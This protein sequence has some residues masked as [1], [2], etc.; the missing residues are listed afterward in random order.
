VKHDRLYLSQAE[1]ELRRKTTERLM[2]HLPEMRQMAQEHES[3]MAYPTRVP[4][5][6]GRSAME[7]GETGLPWHTPPPA[8]QKE[9]LSERFVS[10]VGETSVGFMQGGEPTLWHRTPVDTSQRLLQTYLYSNEPAFCKD[11]PGFQ[12]SRVGHLMSEAPMAREMGPVGPVQGLMFG[13]YHSGAN[14]RFE[15]ETKNFSIGRRPL[16]PMLHSRS[17]VTYQA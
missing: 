14:A 6:P 12:A 4:G 17:P 16:G 1:E 7:S 10:P 3:T 15:H 9:A 13:R 5:P 2:E 11:T 8:E